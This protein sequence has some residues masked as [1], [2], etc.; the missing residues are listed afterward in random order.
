MWSGLVKLWD[1]NPSGM[2]LGVVWALCLLKQES[3]TEEKE[4]EQGSRNLE[5]KHKKYPEAEVMYEA[6]L[7]YSLEV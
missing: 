2:L 5:S 4:T 7:S 6:Q 1:K 3:Q